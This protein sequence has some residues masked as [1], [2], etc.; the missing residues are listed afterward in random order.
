MQPHYFSLEEANAALQII[1]PL[2]DEVQRIRTKIIAQR[3]ELWPAMAR[4][5]GNGGNPTLSKPVKEFD[6]L[7]ELVRQILATG[8]RIK[9]INTGLLDFPALRAGHEVYLCWK[10]GEPEIGFWHEIDAGFAGRQ[11]I[12][13]F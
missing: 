2:M 6:R 3:P 9:D 11:P 1:C 10:V 8:A 7:D 5:V 13:S 4:S 12:D